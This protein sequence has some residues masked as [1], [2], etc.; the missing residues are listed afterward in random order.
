[1][2]Q[3]VCAVDL[4]YTTLPNLLEKQCQQS[5]SFRM[6]VEQSQGAAVGVPLRLGTYEPLIPENDCLQMDQVL[7]KY[8]LPI[9]DST[10]AKQ[11]VASM[12]LLYST[13]N[14]ALKNTHYVNGLISMFARFPLWAH[15]IAVDRITAESES[16]PSRAMVRKIFEEILS[17]V[18][19]L[20]HV[21]K[22]HLLEHRRRK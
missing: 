8:L 18:L 3:I 11:S 6:L 4:N 12:L 17:E 13:G 2:S 9:G 20:R 22:T 16:W 5:S 15:S 19:A 14:K 21:L 7:E 10:E 1:M